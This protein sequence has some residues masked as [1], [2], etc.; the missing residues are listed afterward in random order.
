[1]EPEASLRHSQQPST[2][3]YPEPD[4]SSPCPPPPYYVL[5]RDNELKSIELPKHKFNQA[6]HATLL[7]SW[8]LVSLNNRFRK[9]AGQAYSTSTVGRTS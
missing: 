9:V 8:G 2:C 5:S 1:M 6:V 7:W 4:Q 3:P